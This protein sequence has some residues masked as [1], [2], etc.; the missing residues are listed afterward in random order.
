MAPHTFP[1]IWELAVC[2]P[3][4]WSWCSTCAGVGV[5]ANL[6]D[7]L[8]ELQWRRET[9][10]SCFQYDSCDTVLDSLWIVF[11]NKP[12]SSY[13]E[14]KHQA[15]LADDTA[16]VLSPCTAASDILGAWEHHSAL[17]WK[18][19]RRVRLLLGWN[20]RIETNSNAAPTGL[21][22]IISVFQQRGKETT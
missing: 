7:I 14:V 9:Y 3:T 18:T 22:H 20:D 17:K 13:E 6:S 10:H 8:L 4:L 11:W 19:E 16:A 12:H 5:R 21:D 15:L 1:A 2:S